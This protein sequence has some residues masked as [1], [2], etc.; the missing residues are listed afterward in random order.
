MNDTN[1]QHV[2]RI[3][4]VELSGVEL[5]CVDRH[6]FGYTRILFFERYV[7]TITY[8]ILAYAYPRALEIR[9]RL[10]FTSLSAIYCADRRRDTWCNGRRCGGLHSSTRSA[11]NDAV[12]GE[13]RATEFL[14]ASA[15]LSVA[16]QRGNAMSV[17]GT[18]GST[19]EKLYAL[20]YPQCISEFYLSLEL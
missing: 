1:V 17:M 10:K 15:P 7:R 14:H 11:Y 8:Y 19:G 18:I 20:R 5:S 16:I 12:R 4:P 3:C 6:V 9:K 2:F 13:R